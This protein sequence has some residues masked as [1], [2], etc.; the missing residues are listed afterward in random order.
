MLQ[1]QFI[2]IL[3]VQILIQYVRGKTTTSSFTLTPSLHKGCI[4]DEF[5]QPQRITG[6]DEC[7]AAV[8]SVQSAHFSCCFI[9]TKPT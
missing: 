2:S 4:Q 5:L 6:P 1:L 9:P 8:C 7:P 3:Y